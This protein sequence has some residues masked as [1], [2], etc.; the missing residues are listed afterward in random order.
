LMGAKGSALVQSVYAWNVIAA[1]LERMYHTAIE[2]WGH[3]HPKRG[4]K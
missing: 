4:G 2:N 1:E 3:K